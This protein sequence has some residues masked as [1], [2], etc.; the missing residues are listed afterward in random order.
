M[1]KAVDGTPERITIFFLFIF[2]A[3]TTIKSF[4]I[5]KETNIYLLWA[6]F[7]KITF[8]ICFRLTLIV[9]KLMERAV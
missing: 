3:H 5:K 4:P 2:A 7:L 1:P 9:H 6:A 8:S